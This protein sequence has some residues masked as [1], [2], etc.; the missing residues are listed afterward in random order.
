MKGINEILRAEFGTTRPGLLHT[1]SEALQQIRKQVRKELGQ[2]H[3]VTV[4]SQLLR[5]F[6]VSTEDLEI[7]GI[8]VDILNQFPRWREGSLAGFRPQPSELKPVPAGAAQ[9]IPS[10]RIQLSPAPLTI[11]CALTLLRDLL[12]RLEA[13]VRFTV[14]VETSAS[15]DALRRLVDGF[16]AGAA[17]RVTFAP[18]ASESVFAQ[19]NAR[20]AL[21]SSGRPVL[22]IPREF[23]RAGVPRADELA[24]DEARRVFRTGVIH[25]R[26]YWEGGNVVHDADRLLIGVDTIAENVSRLGLSAREV[27]ALFRAEFGREVT[28]LGDLALARWDSAT[29]KLAKSGQAALHIDMDVSLLGRYG[30]AKQPRALVADAA[31]GLD[32]LPKVLAHKP[33]FADHFVPARRARELIAA[34]YEAYARE[35]HPKL[36]VYAETLQKLGYRVH[37]MPDLRIDPEQDVFRP[38]NLD[39]GYANVLPGLSRGRPAVHYL[40]WG[41]PALDREAERR[42]LRAGVA[43][44]C[45]SSARVAN[46][47]MSLCG[48][49]RCFCGQ[50]T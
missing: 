31:A 38:V 22:L 9:P 13:G 29:G 18:M 12:Q 4:A 8:P 23:N 24:P 6:G 39:F 47:L 36:L 27:L 43:P 3:L 41:I 15:V 2:C 30:R 49:L 1:H 42:L 33:L 32:Y 44:V 20:A 16:Y 25:S 11:S 46:T 40:P 7:A 14:V 34:E 45:V 35:R 28:L 50:M 10:L 17:E 19:D 5:D 37:G 48:G 21:D 26:L